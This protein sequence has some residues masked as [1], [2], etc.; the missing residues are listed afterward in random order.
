M[1]LPACPIILIWHE[2]NTQPHTHTDADIA[3]FLK[4]WC[5]LP[6]IFQFFLY[7]LT[8]TATQGTSQN[9]LTGAN[10][11][12]R[13]AARQWPVHTR[14]ER[15]AQTH[16]LH[17]HVKSCCLH[18]S[19]ESWPCL[20]YISGQTERFSLNLDLI[21]FL[22]SHIVAFSSPRLISTPSLLLWLFF[23]HRL[24]KKRHLET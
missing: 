14:I 20:H 17:C 22:I 11:L 12:T 21:S 13:Q 9:I 5:W 23:H 6:H 8:Q 2:V 18:L 16:T 15:R 1:P 24:L 3:I 4:T 7:S 19:L 10:V